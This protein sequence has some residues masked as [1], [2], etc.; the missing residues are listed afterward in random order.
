MTELKKVV[1]YLSDTFT[2][3]TTGQV[4]EFHHLYCLF[5][6]S[7]AVGSGAECVKI[8]TRDNNIF[9]G[10]NLG[11]YVELR[12]NKYGK[13][14][15]FDIVEPNADDIADFRNVNDILTV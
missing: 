1:G 3:R 12:Y 7:N 13:C 9:N 14:C 15:G 2:D 10:L 8:S 5:P 11:D 6:R 4:I